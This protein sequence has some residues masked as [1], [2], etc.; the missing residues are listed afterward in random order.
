MVAARRLA[1]DSGCTVLLKGA[2]TVVADPDGE[3]LVVTAGDARLATAGTGDVLSGIIGALLAGGMKPLHAAAAGGMGARAGRPA[4]AP[5]R[6]GRQRPSRSDSG[7]AG[8]AAVSRWAWADVDLGAIR[9]NVEVLCATA[10]PAEVWADV[11]ANGYGHGAV[12]GRPGRAAGRC[13]RACAWP[14]CRRAWSCATLGSTARSWSSASSRR[15]LLDRGRAGLELT[16]YSH[17]AARRASP[18]P[19]A[20]DHPVHLKIDTGMRRVGA[21][22]DEALGLAAAIAGSPRRPAWRACCTH[23]ADRRRAGRPV[24]R[25]AAGAVRRRAR[26]AGRRRASPRRSC[27]RPTPRRRSPS[28]SRGFDSCAPASPSTGCRPAP[29]LDHLAG[30]LRPALSLHA[31]VSHVKQVRAG[32][33]ISYGLRHRFDGRHERRHPADR[34][35]RRR[36]A[37]AASPSAARC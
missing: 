31:R 4:R 28:R 17:A 22:A 2:A 37:A 27:T 16:V 5:P 21:A 25:R 26:R 11:K 18:L 29:A 20:A 12:R 13:H 23:L 15:E 14:S 35:R 36:A 7:G 32:D 9:H 24:H 6:P 34:L 19:A 33:R 10:A 1:A 8:R 3:A 30:A